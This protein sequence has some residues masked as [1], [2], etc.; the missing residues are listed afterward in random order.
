M[1][2]FSRETDRQQNDLSRFRTC[3]P[4]FFK[5]VD[6]GSLLMIWL[7]KSEVFPDHIYLKF[8]SHF[9]TKLFK[10]GVCSGCVL[11]LDFSHEKDFPQSKL[12]LRGSRTLEELLSR[13]PFPR[14]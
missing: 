9:H 6:W 4:A 8:K 10:N 11:V 5:G 1:P 3:K 13:A 7:D 12:L 14:R 2:V